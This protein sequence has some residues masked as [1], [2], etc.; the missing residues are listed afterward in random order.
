[1]DFQQGIVSRVPGNPALAHAAE[2]LAA[3]RAA[4]VPVFHIA[5]RLLP[6]HVDVS[7][8]NRLFGALP[9]DVYTAD[10]P[11][12]ALTAELA[13]AEGELVVHKN[14]VSA[15]AGNNLRQLLDARGLTHLVLAG[16]ATGGVVLS[17]ALQAVDLDYD[18][19]VLSDACAD[20]DA[21]LHTTLLDSVLARRGTVTTVGAWRD[22][23][24][25]AADAG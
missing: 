11:A 7:P 19:T 3:A 9:A 10:D 21:A 20:A 24:G 23:L 14:R 22:A 5:L 25:T 1:M 12:T 4:D 6:G 16:I 13:P 18:V 2:A 15:F 8:R 17:T